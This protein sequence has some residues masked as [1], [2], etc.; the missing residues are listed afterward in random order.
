MENKQHTLILVVGKTSSGKTSLIKKVCERTGLKQLISQTTRPR[1]SDTDNDHYFVTEEDYARAKLNGDIVA[2]TEIAGYHYYA[3][4]GQLY[5]ADFYTIDPAGLEVLLSM[6]LPNIRFV[7][8]Y[9]SCP[10]DIREDR[11]INRRGDD[12][13][14]Y[15]T[16]SFS[17]NTQFRRFIADE[18]W[19]Y[20]IKNI[21]FA[22]SYA[23]LKWITAIEKVWMNHKEDTTE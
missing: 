2:E 18:K 17:E 12:K 23:M 6:N 9:I 16:R 19:D 5:E 3:T 22:K 13:R 1:R 11:A 10:D 4:K 14:T 8:V 20:G 15:R 21:D 7:I